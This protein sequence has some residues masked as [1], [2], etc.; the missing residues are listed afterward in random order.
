MRGEPSRESQESVRLTQSDDTI[1]LLALTSAT[2]LAFD[3][4]A[5]AWWAAS[6]RP[7]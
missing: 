7:A 1:G 3:E 4:I 5:G 2:V 6:R